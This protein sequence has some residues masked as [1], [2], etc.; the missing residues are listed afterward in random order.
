MHMAGRP[1]REAEAGRPS[2]E[3]SN[4]AG[5][6][7]ICN[8]SLPA[9]MFCEG[10]ADVVAHGMLLNFNVRAASISSGRERERKA[11]T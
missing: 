7:H 2:P 5:R 1:S 11:T 3:A 9:C 4:Q 10:F 6:L 8:R